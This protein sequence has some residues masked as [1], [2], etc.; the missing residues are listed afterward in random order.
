[1]S[2]KS[3]IASGLGATLLASTMFASAAHAKPP[4]QE[5]IQLDEQSSIAYIEVKADSDT[6]LI[7]NQAWMAHM[8][9]LLKSTDPADKAELEQK[10]AILMNALNDVN[11]VETMNGALAL[12]EQQGITE[13]ALL[14]NLARYGLTAHD[15][16]GASG[17]LLNM[18]GKVNR[19]D[20][21]RSGKKQRIA[22][23]NIL[24]EFAEDI[25]SID[26]ELTADQAR[27]ALTI[28]N[29]TRGIADYDKKRD[30][31]DLRG[32]EAM[33]GMSLEGAIQVQPYWAAR[34]G[35]IKTLRDNLGNSSKNDIAND[36]VF[37]LAG[38]IDNIDVGYAFMNL[39]ADRLDRRPNID[40]MACRA[41]GWKASNLYSAFAQ[42]H[43]LT[44]DPDKTCKKSTH[45]DRKKNW[46][47]YPDVQTSMSYA[48][49]PAGQ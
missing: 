36:M 32:I 3:K 11:D 48:P 40:K 26:D 35:D 37:D 8:G 6:R 17:V 20:D 44:I 4:K 41:E 13:G 24:L 38:D 5:V 16:K 30:K 19:F 15:F 23:Q 10:S 27:K 46:T 12:I 43:S 1:M 18:A 21:A 25:N 29:I 34:Q 33:A 47:Y 2:V 39:V 9:A 22:A 14:E 42:S 7:L 49:E 45:Y 28:I 31:V